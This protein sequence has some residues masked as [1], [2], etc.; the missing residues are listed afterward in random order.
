VRSFRDSNVRFRDLVREVSAGEYQFPNT[1]F[2]TGRSSE[3]GAYTLAD[4]TWGDLLERL[5]K[6]HFQ[7]VDRVLRARILAFYAKRPEKVADKRH[8]EK[9][10]AELQGRVDRLAAL[11]REG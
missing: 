1:N 5:D 3:R 10:R 8:G 11:Q 6:R 2:D 7:G 9:H 4:E